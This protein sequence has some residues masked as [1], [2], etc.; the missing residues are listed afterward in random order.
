M[1]YKKSHRL[2][3]AGMLSMTVLTVVVCL[4]TQS[5][6]FIYLYIAAVIIWT[7]YLSKFCRCPHCGGA[8]DFRGKLPDYCPHCG[9]KLE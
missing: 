1:D 4:L 8:F 6:L 7:I 2:Y 9:E 5:S 3:T